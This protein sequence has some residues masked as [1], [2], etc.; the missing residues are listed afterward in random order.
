MIEAD[1][2]FSL[3]SQDNAVLKFVK[4]ELDRLYKR[5]I[6]SNSNLGGKHRLTNEDIAELFHDIIYSD[7][8]KL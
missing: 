4:I 8:L 1:Y 5:I 6:K 7:I 3:S 2:N